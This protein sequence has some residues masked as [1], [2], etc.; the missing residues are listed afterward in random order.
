MVP[1]WQRP[2]SGIIPRILPPSVGN[3][4][5]N[6][7]IQGPRQIS[8]SPLGTFSVKPEER[9]WSYS[10]K[11]SRICSKAKRFSVNNLSQDKKLFKFYT[12]FTKDQ[13]SCL[14]EL[15]G[16]EMNT[17]SYWGSLSALN[18][19]DEGLGGSKPGPSRKL[20]PKDAKNCYISIKEICLN[21]TLPIPSY[22]LNIS[23]NSPMWSSKMDF[24]SKAS[25][26]SMNCKLQNTKRKPS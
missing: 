11:I 5:P 4:V 14:L 18:P 23:H 6:P 8:T 12:G 20:P 7:V 17:L 10:K 15:H 26:A 21:A 25:D 3:A 13:F 16:K 24:L 22:S 9:N 1:G 2:I 19:N